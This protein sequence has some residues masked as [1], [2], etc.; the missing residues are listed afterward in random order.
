MTIPAYLPYYI[1]GGS[2]AIIAAVLFGLNLGLKRANWLDRERTKVVRTTALILIG[3]FAA[4]VVLASLG[5]Y[6]GAPDRMPTLQYAI[7]LP[8]LIGALLIGRSSTVSR[9]LDAVPQEWMVAVQVYRALGL[10]FLVLYFSGN[11]PG[12]FAWPAGLGDIAVGLLAPVVALAFARDPLANAGAVRSWNLFGIADLI[13]AVGT[14]FLTS[15]SPL[16]LFAFDNPSELISAFP[17][18][19]VPSYL[20]PL[21]IVLHLASLTKL[22]RMAKSA[23]ATLES[24]SIEPPASVRREGARHV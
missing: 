15:P 14:G 21:S 23:D 5:V 20:V 4:T 8:I 24:R 13:V 10:I 7:V 11:L 6:H 22:R 17:L 9:L 18:V 12:L 1:V 2:I 3:W 19:L 16:Q